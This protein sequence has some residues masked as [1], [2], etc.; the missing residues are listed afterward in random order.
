[1]GSLDALVKTAALFEVR[2]LRTI[3]TNLEEIFMAYYGA[4]DGAV[5]KEAGHAAA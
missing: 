2:N 3:E 1:M 4:G 5:A